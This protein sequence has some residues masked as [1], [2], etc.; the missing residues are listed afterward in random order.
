MG[1]FGKPA[2][3]TLLAKRFVVCKFENFTLQVLAE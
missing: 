3:V 2:N 1:Q